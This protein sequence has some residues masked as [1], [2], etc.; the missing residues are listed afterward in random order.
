MYSIILLNQIFF[1]KLLINYNKID[2][3]IYTKNKGLYF[4]DKDYLNS[5]KRTILDQQK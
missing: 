3:I 1:L 2:I 4:E 5:Y